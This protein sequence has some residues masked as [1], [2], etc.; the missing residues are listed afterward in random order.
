MVKR[1]ESSA[2]GIFIALAILWAAHVYA[3]Y[4]PSGQVWGILH[5]LALPPLWRWVVWLAGLSLIFPPVAR[6]GARV[7]GK[8]HLRLPGALAAGTVARRV[9]IFVLLFVPLFVFR[10]RAHIFGDGYRMLDRLAEA[11]PSVLFSADILKETLD[12]G[13]HWLNHRLW[14]EPLGIS[15]ALTYG[16]LNCIAG[17]ILLLGLTRLI[18][19]L[20]PHREHRLLLWSAILSSGTLLLGLGYVESYTWAL[21]GSVWAMVYAVRSVN[22][23]GL[24]R[25]ALLIWIVAV[26]FH[27]LALIFAP[28]FL[29]MLWRDKIK[30]PPAIKPLWSFVILGVLTIGGA[31]I[32]AR[33]LNSQLFVFPS[34]G[35]SS[36]YLLWSPAHLIDT[37]NILL[38]VAPAFF[39]LIIPAL[40]AANQTKPGQAWGFVFIAAI[41][42][43]WAALVIDPSLGAARD[44]DLISYFGPF[45]G[46][47]MAGLFLIRRPQISPT[48]VRIIAVQLLGLG[49][50]H[51]VPWVAVHQNAAQAVETMDV[52]L[53][54]DPHLSV[55]YDQ[56]TRAVDFAKFLITDELQRYDL[57]TKYYLRRVAVVP[58]DPDAWWSLGSMYWYRGLPDSCYRAYRRSLRADSTNAVY[59][60]NF[61][62]LLL[63]Q[64][65]VAEAKPCFF[66]VLKL[67]PDNWQ[68][69]WGLGEIYRREKKYDSAVTMFHNVARIKPDFWEAY[70]AAGVELMHNKDYQAALDEFNQA[71]KLNPTEAIMYRRMLEISLLHKNVSA[72]QQVLQNWRRAATPQTKDEIRQWASLVDSIPTLALDDI[73][74]A[75]LFARMGEWYTGRGLDNVAADC[76]YRATQLDSINNTYRTRYDALRAIMKQRLSDLQ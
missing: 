21:A 65:R 19:E 9:I 51:T 6:A 48:T 24:W 60:H 1:D 69:C 5:G 23:P 40:S 59:W 13:W 44:W 58:D 41:S 57:G 33:L 75:E 8:L 62:L 47:S 55:E 14:A 3:A 67:Q 45:L 53:V 10:S 25:V 15:P 35:Q 17:V 74:A 16:F 42:A 22:K 66:K 32:A 50:F 76:F 11:G 71:L 30:Q 31:L 37:L 56:A 64:N 18:K 52:M 70:C 29:W 39:V 49:I 26:G 2:W 34:P 38:L 12:F 68:V 43:W 61:G 54:D 7:I 73:T 46:L 20:T 63:G 28:A 72:M 36:P 4:Y 27:L